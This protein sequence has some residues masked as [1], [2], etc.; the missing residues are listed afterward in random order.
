M[1]WFTWLLAQ[2]IVGNRVQAEE[3]L[4]LLALKLVAVGT[5]NP[6]GSALHLCGSAD[7]PGDGSILRRSRN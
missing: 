7:D 3:E 1:S 2:G 4:T 6:T 5:E